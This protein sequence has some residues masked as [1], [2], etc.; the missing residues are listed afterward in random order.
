MHAAIVVGEEDAPCGSNG[1][2]P[3]GIWARP[4]ACAMWRTG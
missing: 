3:P 2:L 4:A 1:S